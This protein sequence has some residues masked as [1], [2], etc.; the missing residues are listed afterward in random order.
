MDTHHRNTLTPCHG[1]AVNQHNFA[2]AR[3]HLRITTHNVLPRLNVMTFEQRTTNSW[4]FQVVD[5]LAST[6]T[7]SIKCHKSHKI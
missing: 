2:R 5:I 1:N 6:Y 4:F 3:Y 7:L